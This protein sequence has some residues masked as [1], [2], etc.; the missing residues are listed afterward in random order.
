M[1]IIGYVKVHLTILKIQMDLNLG[2]INPSYF[3][4]FCLDHYVGYHHTPVAP[5]VRVFN[6]INIQKNLDLKLIKAR[7]FFRSA[8]LDFPLI[9]SR[10][11]SVRC[12]D[13]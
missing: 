13:T 2:L 12:L 8:L 6:Y 3:L 10:I 11:Y 5:L 1:Y 4:R 7:F 9:C